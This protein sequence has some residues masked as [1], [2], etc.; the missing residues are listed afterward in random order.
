MRPLDRVALSCGVWAADRADK[1]RDRHGPDEPTF[2]MYVRIARRFANLAM[3][4]FE[5]R[6]PDY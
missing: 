6:F 2:A 1:V 5:R 4:L 3:W